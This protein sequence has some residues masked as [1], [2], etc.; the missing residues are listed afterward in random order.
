MVRLRRAPNKRV[1]HHSV[2]APVAGLLYDSNTP[3]TMIEEHHTPDCSDVIMDKC[4]VEKQT[5]TSIFGDTQTTPLNGTVMHIDQYYTN[6]GSDRLIAHTTSDVY[7]YDPSL[8]HFLNITKG[9]VV[10]DCEDSW[11]SAS[12]EVTSETDEDVKWRGSKSVKL[13]FTDAFTTGVAAYENGLGGLD[14]TPYT[15]LHFYIRSSTDT[16]EGDLQILLDEHDNCASP[17]DT[18]SVP[19]LTA[20][21]W[22][23]CNVALTG[24]EGDMD[25]IVS[26]GLKVANDLDQSFTI[27]IDDVR[28]TK[29]NTGDEDNTYTSEIMSELYIFNNGVD[30]I[31][32]WDMQTNTVQDLGGASNYRCK[33]MITYGE[34]LCLFHTIESG[35][36]YPQRVRWSVVGDPEDWTGAGSGATT[37]VGVLGIDFIQSVQKLSNYVVIYAERTIAL[38]EYR[39]TDPSDP[40]A[41]LTRVAGMGLAAPRAIVNLDEEHIFLG[42]DNVYSYK[43]GRDIEPIGDAIKEE[44]FRIIEPKYIH[45]SF[46]T[47]IEEKNEIRLY[48][49][50]VG[51]EYPNTYFS[52][53]TST[54]GWSRGT[55]KYTTYGYYSQQETYTWDGT[56]GSWDEQ[57]MR[58]DDRT[59]LS[60]SP[61]NLFGNE[62]GEVWKDDDSVYTVEGKDVD[63]WWDTKDFVIGERYV[64]ETTNWMGVNFEAM[65]TNLDVLI[66]SDLGKTYQFVESVSLT[67]KW[68]KYE[69]DF[70]E[71]SP[72]LRVRFRCKSGWFRM[73]QIELEYVR[74]SDR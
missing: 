6:D 51:S 44:L 71:W 53:N 47:F 24:D 46:M 69:V 72:Y 49:P 16:E 52:L 63:A 67:S 12:G 64:E 30:S 43:G 1:Q 25:T 27:W 41:F 26:V 11:T 65:G 36:T 3:S 28:A 37:L 4:V 73:R 45:R 35:Y 59:R 22:K 13:T 17:S 23:E 20:G 2:Y 50:T 39:G 5:G 68:S 54:N 38:M 10:E 42:W 19:A 15:H 29:P 57:T 60:L 8:K 40:F 62:K 31:K 70:E 61:I 18:L 34:R 56:S 32:K 33:A 21:E 9:L 14:L 48:V 55:R 66:S 74:G 7:S 58:W